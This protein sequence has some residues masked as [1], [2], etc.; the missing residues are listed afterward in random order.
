MVKVDFGGTGKG[1]EWVT[2]NIDGQGIAHPAPDIA[3]DVTSML[4][5][6]SHFPPDCIDEARCIATFE[7]LPA[8]K[9]VG[10]LRAW[11]DLLKTDARLVIMVPDVRVLAEDW[12]AGRIS[13]RLFMDCVFSPPEWT[14]KLP[15]EL[16]RY[17]FD[18]ALLVEMLTEAGYR[19]ARVF[20][21]PQ[22]TFFVDGYPVPN[23]WVEAWK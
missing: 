18:G 1:G 8:H 21:G 22:A 13:T 2:V 7:H 9:L 4:Q 17:G 16:H 10:T 3:A 23:L 14:R 12:L 5:L 20:A 6:L 19:D 15:G 11:R